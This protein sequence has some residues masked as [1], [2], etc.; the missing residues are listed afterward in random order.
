MGLI[1]NRKKKIEPPAEELGNA[2]IAKR[3]SMQTVTVQRDGVT[4][5][6]H[7]DQPVVNA[8][9]ITQNDPITPGQTVSKV[10]VTSGPQADHGAA[11]YEFETLSDPHQRSR[12]WFIG[13]AV[14]FAAAVALSIV[15][16]LYLSAVVFFVVAL[17]GFTNATTK[18]KN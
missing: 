2:N 10:A 15:L 9:V 17:L 11:I 5:T 12:G 7:V 1:F 13:M 3:I 8:T 18:K 14:F 6:E 16:T 4:H